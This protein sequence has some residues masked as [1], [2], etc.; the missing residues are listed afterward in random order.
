VRR[1]ERGVIVLIYAIGMTAMV[2]IAAMVIDLAQLRTDR[3]INKT[4]ADTAVRAGLGV[5]QAGPWS[6]VCR[7]REYLRTNAPGMTNFDPGSEKWFQVAAPLDSLTSSPCVNTTNAPFINLCLPGQLGIP[8]TDT[9]GRLTATAGNGRYTIEIQSGYMLPDP[10]F[11][12]DQVALTDTGDVLKGYCDN[13]SVIITE[14]RSPFFGRVAGGGDR[15]TTVRSVGRLSSISTGEYNPALLLLEREKCDVLVAGSNNT[16]V[17]AQ[18]FLDHPGVIQIDSADTVGC[19]NGQAVLNGAATNSGQPSILA[20]GAKTLQLTPG[21]NAG[22]G[23]KPSRIGIYALHFPHAPGDRVTT[24]YPATYGD[25]L[26]V[27]SAQSGRAPIDFF[28]RNNVKI[29]DAS[30][31]TLLKGSGGLPPGCTVVNNAC[32]DSGGTTW[33]VLSQADCNTLNTT[34][35]FHFFNPLIPVVPLR[36]LA[37]NIWFNCDLSVKTPLPL[38]LDGINSTIVVTGQLQ[39]LGVFSISD[40]R[41]IYIG[42]RSGG[43][44]IGLDIGNGGVFSVNRATAVDCAAR[45]LLGRG[46]KMVVGDGSFIVAS[47]GQ[48][49]LCQTFVY[50]ASG[51][52]KVPSTDNTAPCTNPCGTYS[53]HISI[54]SGSSVDWSAPN[55]ITN[56]RPEFVDVDLG[57]LLPPISPYEDIAFWTEAGGNSHSISGNGS[58]HMTGVFFLGNADSFNLAGNSGANVYLSAQFISR[59]MKV[60]GG[61]VVNLVINPLDAIPIVVYELLL[62]R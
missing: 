39:V 16:R 30:A 62:V 46:T 13:L 25:T 60:T 36:T 6:G 33:L 9:W 3:R 48:A 42:G 11:P 15:I 14:K 23:D 52:D 58:T 34:S 19:S 4:V 28:Y 44:K 49:Y 7:A 50:M 31:K 38:S 40:P 45:A 29:L 18:P 8:R 1:D 10:R 59:T 26:A 53:G 37:P 51:F 55:L 41:S 17:I 57:G 21:C 5:L 54:G 24:D 20:C 2:T 47:S 61:A 27:P 35:L 56:R 12:E 32:T 43:N 22:V